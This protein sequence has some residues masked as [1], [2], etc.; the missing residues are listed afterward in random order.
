MKSPAFLHDS[1]FEDRQ[2]DL[3]R[4]RAAVTEGAR[5]VEL[6]GPVGVGKSMLARVALQRARDEGWFDATFVVPARSVRTA[7]ELCDA[8]AEA[9][10]SS[11]TPGAA[12]LDALAARGSVCVLVDDLDAPDVELARALE[13]WLA[14]APGLS[15]W[16][17]RR[18]RLGSEQGRPISVA[19]WPAGAGAEGP[20]FRLFVTEVRKTR[21]DYSPSEAELPFLLELLDTLEGLPL[22]LVLTAP[23]LGV[24]GA[25]ALLH[26]IRSSRG[27]AS[28]TRDASQ[29]A[30]DAALTGSWQ[31]LES[32]E[33]QALTGLTAFAADFTVD[34]AEAVLELGPGAPA[35]ADVLASLR[36]KALLETRADVDGE[37]RLAL[38]GVVRDFALRHG[39]TGARHKAAERHRAHF[40]ELARE[41]L[42]E[43]GSRATRVAFER[44]E[45]HAVVE[46][47]LEARELTRAQAEPAL[48]ALLALGPAEGEAPALRYLALVEPVI[49]ATRKS[50]AD[51]ELVARALLVSARALALS[52]DTLGAVRDHGHALHVALTLGSAELEYQANLGLCRTLSETRELEA[53]KRHALTAV[54]LAAKSRD[55]RGEAEALVALARVEARLGSAKPVLLLERAA[56]VFD[57]AGLVTERHAALLELAGAHLDRGAPEDARRA[58]TAAKS[59]ALPRPSR[60]ADVVE[61]RIAVDESTLTAPGPELRRLVG[62]AQRASDALAEATARALFG[63]ASVEAGELGEAHAQLSLA[64]DERRLDAGAHEAI[65]ATLAWLDVCFL[66]DAGARPA[67]QALPIASAWT[68]LA[69]RACAREPGGTSG[70]PRALAVADDGRW[71]RTP[72]GKSVSLERRRPLAKLLSELARAREGGPGVLDWQALQAAGWPG[73][74]VLPAAGAHR[75]R[76]AISTLRK[77]G[78][79]ELLVTRGSGYC[80]SPEVALARDP[81]HDFETS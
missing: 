20:A 3:E 30:F 61:A 59:L 53:A 69:L 74:K 11:T 35:V 1:T 4:L 68:R 47:V 51:P 8:I 23:R 25:R 58:L 66:S 36:S 54:E 15:F 39:E 7:A 37:V 29:L 5:L 63:F 32:W 64:K 19:P 41:A 16:V 60:L 50:G 70:S 81:S 12:W 56:A 38:L 55:R 40:G 18:A 78:L 31:A 75:V 45:L 14:E 26:R 44:R 48:W 62:E 2:D 79:G 65:A 71:F 6:S 17:T 67:F 42:R 21:P 33:Q 49:H 80:L 34:A 43:A 46:S 77:L 22:A 27:N 13:E 28:A 24:M 52:G 9:T 73:E 72:D 76:V 10:T 57:A